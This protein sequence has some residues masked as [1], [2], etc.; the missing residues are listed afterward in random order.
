LT[1]KQNHGLIKLFSKSV[2]MKSLV[3]YSYLP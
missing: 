1:I 3:K 2:H